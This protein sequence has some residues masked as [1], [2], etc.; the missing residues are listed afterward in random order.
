MNFTEIQGKVGLKFSLLNSRRVKHCLKDM[1]PVKRDQDPLFATLLKMRQ[2]C[3][4]GNFALYRRI[5]KLLYI[6]HGWKSIC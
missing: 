3:K 6:C 4:G 1:W 2:I 5:K